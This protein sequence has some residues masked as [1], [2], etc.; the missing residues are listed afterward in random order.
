MGSPSRGFQPNTAA[1]SAGMEPVAAAVARAIARPP[2]RRY[3]AVFYK[4]IPERRAIRIIPQVSPRTR[5]ARPCCASKTG[6]GA[7]VRY[8]G[9][10][11]RA[12]GLVLTHKRHNGQAES[13]DF[14]SFPN[15]KTACSRCGIVPFAR[16]PSHR[17][18]TRQ[19]QS[20]AEN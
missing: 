17:R 3:K 1:I 9:V 12:R 13:T 15:V 14:A 4:Q 18:G 11:C 6:R 8:R 10:T 20:D 19:S 7:D 5:R 2:S 16:Q